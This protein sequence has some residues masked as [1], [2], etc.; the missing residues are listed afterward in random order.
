MKKLK[1]YALAACTLVWGLGC[2]STNT[3]TSTASGSDFDPTSTTT[4]NRGSNATITGNSINFN[5]DTNT[6]TAAI[7]STSFPNV[8]A[9]SSMF[10]LLSSQEVQSRGVHPQVRQFAE[11]MITDH[12]K[13]SA[14][15]KSIATDYKFALP[16]AMIPRHQRMLQEIRNAEAKDFDEA[17]MDGQVMAHR[18][19]VTLFER[20]AKNETNPALKAFASKTLPALKMHLD[21]AKTI[22]DMVDEDNRAAL[23]DE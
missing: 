4:T 9:S 23:V 7:D 21:K 22:E 12:T 11:Q 10:E 2:S 15:L 8:A 17:Y 20:A 6:E 5:T 3:G 18:E 16:D 13:S 1:M 14:E 19:A